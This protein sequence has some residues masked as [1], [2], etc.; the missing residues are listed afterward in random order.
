MKKKTTSLL[1]RKRHIV[2]LFTLLIV[3][4]VTG[5]LFIDSV[6]IT[7]E[8]DGQLVDYAKAGTVATFKING[9]IDVNGDPRNDK[10][11]VVGFC[12]PKSWNLAQN[13]KVTYTENICSLTILLH[14]SSRP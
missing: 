5:C 4:V 2:A 1:Q 6:D 7:Q 3:F 10:R 9:H 11:L 14:E 13:A 12:A 8:V